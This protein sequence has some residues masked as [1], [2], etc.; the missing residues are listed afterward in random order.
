MAIPAFC[1]AMLE[2]TPVQPA[3]MDI[4]ALLKVVGVIAQ[5]PLLFL[6]PS[7]ALAVALITIPNNAM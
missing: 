3:A 1:N 4:G 5:P 6:L 2:D 7:L